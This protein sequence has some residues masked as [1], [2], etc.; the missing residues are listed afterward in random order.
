MKKLSV[1]LLALTLALT[2]RQNAF[3]GRV[4]T[5]TISSKILGTDVPCNVYVPD[6]WDDD[7]KQ[8]PVVYLLHGLSDTYEGWASHG[9]A[10]LIAD[11]LIDAGDI[12]EMVIIMPNAGHSNPR[13]VLN[14]YF[15]TPGR[16]YEDFFF[17]ELMPQLE[18]KYR[19]I[20]DKKHRAIMGLSMGGGGSTVYCQHHPEMFSSCYAMSPWLDEKSGEVGGWDG[21]DD[22]LKVV[23][24]SVRQNSALDFVD[25]ASEET[26]AAL[27]T[28]RWTF[29]IGDDD[30]LLP[31]STDMHQKMNARGIRNEL[32]VR[33][34]NHNWEYWPMIL[35]Y[36]LQFASVGFAN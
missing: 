16:N 10:S 17:Q 2:I 28:V 20:G 19:C 23:C 18:A 24:Q 21:P 3:A 1:I 15:N 27:K 36:A 26:V 25:N 29:D 7:T 32:R 8:Y 30:W 14:G 22:Q 31:L 34:G 12:V 13:E 9:R 4:I 6:G 5:E 11:R 33:D 35:P